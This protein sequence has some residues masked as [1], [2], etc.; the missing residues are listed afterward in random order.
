M[1]FCVFDVCFGQID[2]ED[3][4]LRPDLFERIDKASCTAAEIVLDVLGSIDGERVVIDRAV[5]V[6]AVFAHLVTGLHH[7]DH[8][9]GL[10]YLLEKLGGPFHSPPPSSDSP[11]SRSISS[12]AK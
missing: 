4:K 5:F 12:A 9:Q 3:R 6:S 7:I 2:A 11:R 10:L 1:P 8:G